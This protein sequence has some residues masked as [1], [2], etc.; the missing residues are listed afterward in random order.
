MRLPNNE[1]MS[2]KGGSAYGR[3]KILFVTR[4]ICPPWD[5]ASKNF[6]YYLAKNIKGFEIH[7]LTNGILPN[8]PENIIQENIYNS[9]GFG[10]SQKIKLFRFLRKNRNN[11]DIIHYLFTPTK[12]NSFFIKNFAKPK[13]GKSIQTIATLRED[14]YSDDDLKK[15][16]FAD[17]IITYS[18]YSKNKLKSLGLKNAL[19][20]S[21]LS[22]TTRV[23]AI[24]PGIDLD[25]YSPVSKD[26]ELMKKF[27][28][29]PDDFVINFAGEYTRLGAI[30]GVIDSFLEISEK[31]PNAKLSLAVRIKN[32]KD[33]EKKRE[34]IEKLKEAGV[35][36]KVAFQDDGSYQMQDVFNLCDVSIFPVQNMKGK[37][38]VPL[39]VIEAMAC[40]KPVIISDLPIFQEF[41]NE[42]NSVKIE[43]GNMEKLFQ[44]VLDV[45]ENPERYAEIGKNS[46]KFVEENFDIKKVAEKYQ[47]IYGEL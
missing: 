7:L 4:P 27:G 42:Q 5:E 44:A 22:S 30:D 45:K 34:V 17:S 40:E 18:D 11:F 13:R 36:E 25:L 3:K 31:I 10:L 16:L 38:D 33:A 21:E 9:G 6:A 8:L 41:A 43:A 12:Q 2:A 14:L 19:P 46:R 39:S 15:I 24:Y 23:E 37:F 35:F 20:G 32:E 26:P 47:K 1:F 29:T 28:F